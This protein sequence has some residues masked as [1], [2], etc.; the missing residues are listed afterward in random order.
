MGSVLL[1]LSVAWNGLRVLVSKSEA[2]GP[3][4]CPFYQ[5]EGPTKRKG[6]ERGFFGYSAVSRY[7]MSFTE[8]VGNWDWVGISL[9]KRLGLRWENS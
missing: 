8:K 6:F 2:S 4:I 5:K 9:G 3:D 7:G 1:R